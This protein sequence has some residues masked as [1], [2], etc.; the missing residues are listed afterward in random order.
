MAGV[1]RNWF[2]KTHPVSFTCKPGEL[3]PCLVLP[4]VP[5]DKVRL[6]NTLVA[7]FPALVAPAF[8]AWTAVVHYF[9]VSNRIVWQ[10]FDEWFQNPEDV[11][12]GVPRFTVQ[13]TLT[14]TQQRFM[15][16]FGIPPIAD[17]TA[18]EDLEISAFPFAAFQKIYNDWYRPRP[19][20]DPV[21]FELPAAG[22]NVGGT[23][24]TA[25]LTDRLKSWE[26]D[27]HTSML[28]EPLVAPEVTVPMTITLD[29][30]FLANGSLPTFSDGAIPVHDGF[31][32]QSAAQLQVDSAGA[33]PIDPA[34]YDPDGSLVTQ[35]TINVLREAYARMRYLEKMGRV[36]G[37][38]Y[39][40][41]Q[42][43]YN[44]RI[45]DA[46][47]QRSEYITG[48][49]VPISINPVL[50]TTQV[51][52]YPI[53]QQAGHMVGAGSG[54]GKTFEAEE[55]GYIIGIFSIIP[56]PVYKQGVPRHFRAFSR[57]DFI[58]PDLANIGEQEVLSYEINAYE[59]DQN[60]LTTIG[61][62]PNYTHHKQMQGR[63]AGEF[64]S[65]LSHYVVVKQYTG[66][67]T[68]N[69][70]FVQVPTNI[71][72]HIFV[73]DAD[74]SDPVWINMLHGI[75]HETCLPVYSDPI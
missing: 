53:G 44:K 20:Q 75:A 18:E 58:I 65:D 33:P 3:V 69:T 29:P 37:E 23:V 19:F 47:L 74:I 49:K 4:V 16:F 72:D 6:D 17:S 9:Y 39:E 59:E 34:G 11:A 45:S 10:S 38:Y 71:A 31:V 24:R 14:A 42:A 67:P 30:D 63:I 2:D 27:Y 12:A 73:A 25:L 36:G 22:G 50:A 46:R 8:V 70:A 62:L 55:H 66:V 35:T 61:Y 41:I 56:K 1:D 48:S 26:H 51:T 5:G 32:L 43:V 15:D 57:E 21:T 54:G 7:R 28:P 68:L 64:R 40:I 52:D 13:N 60:D